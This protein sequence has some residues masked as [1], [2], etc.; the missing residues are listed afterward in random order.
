MEQK[1]I[2]QENQSSTFKK[3]FQ[4]PELGFKGMLM[5]FLYLF[6]LAILIYFIISAIG[7]AKLQPSYGESYSKNLSISLSMFLDGIGEGG[8]IFVFAI[9]IVWSIMI[10][11]SFLKS[12]L[13]LFGLLVLFFIIMF[14]ILTSEERGYLVL[15]MFFLVPVAIVISLPGILMRAYYKIQSSAIKISLLIILPILLTIIILFS[16][17]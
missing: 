9:P 1:I 17:I 5:S 6:L 12:L 15:G 4:K 11:K 14:A 16:L 8:I 13:V 10:H 3:W 7:G 2:N